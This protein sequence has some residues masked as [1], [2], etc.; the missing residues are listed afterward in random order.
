MFVD[1]E[2]ERVF[3]LESARAL[4]RQM[5]EARMD[6]KTKGKFSSPEAR[7]KL[8]AG[9]DMAMESLEGR[10]KRRGK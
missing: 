6:I 4:L 5:D 8:L 10:I 2:G 7:T 1:L 9:Y 3:E